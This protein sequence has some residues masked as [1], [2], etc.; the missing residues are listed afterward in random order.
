MAIQPV[1]RT[2]RWLHRLRSEAHHRAQRIAGGGTQTALLSADRVSG[3]YS[4]L[5]PRRHTGVP[6]SMTNRLNLAR[7]N[8][9]VER[10]NLDAFRELR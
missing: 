8:L 1:A 9:G 2:A 3:S 10:G 7:L 5:I 6:L 4:I